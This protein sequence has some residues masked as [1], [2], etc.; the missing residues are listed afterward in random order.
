MNRANLERLAP[1]VTALIFLVLWWL[2]V[3][4]FHIENF[5]LPS[6]TEAFAALYDFRYP[7]MMHGLATL[8]T[9]VAGFA[10]AV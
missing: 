2:V 5:V 1:W 9:T 3:K 4:I 6:P 10:I 8:G 7:L